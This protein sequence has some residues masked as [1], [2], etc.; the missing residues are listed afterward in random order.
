MSI[1]GNRDAAQPH[2]RDG[3]AQRKI[4]PLLPSEQGAKACAVL[5]GDLEFDCVQVELGP[6]A[7]IG[8][9]D[10]GDSG[11]AGRIPPARVIGSRCALQ[12]A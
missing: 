2:H 5:V 9:F 3:E 7:D 6:H 4:H 8:C 10:V 11:I 1:L 12:G